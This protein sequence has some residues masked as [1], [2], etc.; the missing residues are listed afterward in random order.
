M[1]GAKLMIKYKTLLALVTDIFS[2]SNYFDFFNIPKSLII[3]LKKG[4]VL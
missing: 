1:S 3:F 4:R 2:V